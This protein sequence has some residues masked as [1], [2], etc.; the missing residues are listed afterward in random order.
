MPEAAGQTNWLIRIGGLRDGL[1]VLASLLYGLGY[2]VWSLHAWENH[3]GL[4]PALDTQYFVAGVFPALVLVVAFWTFKLATRAIE[5]F[6]FWLYSEPRTRIKTFVQWFTTAIGLIP[7]AVLLLTA[8]NADFRKV[9]RPEWTAA[10]LFGGG[11]LWSLLH[12]RGAKDFNSNWERF[13][14]VFLVGNVITFGAL[15]AVLYFVYWVYPILPQELGGVKPRCAYLDLTRSQLST[16]TISALVD[17]DE[18]RSSA[19]VVRS[20]RLEIPYSSS[21]VVMVRVQNRVYELDR[22]AVEAIT[23]CDGNV[24]TGS[25][26][27]FRAHRTP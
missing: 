5:R 27:L 25:A 17:G 24:T 11:S 9:I 22:K 20:R 26:E 7:L 4:L 8:F 6:L 1:L 10:A 2:L 14:R 12:T 3:L 21:E 16:A 13:Y 23:S 19:P 18:L 15:F